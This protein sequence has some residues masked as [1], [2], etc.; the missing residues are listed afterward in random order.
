M[1]LVELPISNL[2]AAQ[3][4]FQCFHKDLVRSPISHWEADARNVPGFQ[5]L[6]LQKVL[7]VPQAAV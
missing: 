4:A 6:D 1:I 3:A 7:H 2:M 5:S